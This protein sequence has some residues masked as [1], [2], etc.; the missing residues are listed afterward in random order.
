MR[1]ERAVVSLVA[2]YLLVVFSCSALE[3]DD[4]GTD[5]A[6][7]SDRDC[8]DE[9]GCTRDECVSGDSGRICRH[10]PR[11]SPCDDGDPCTSPDWC[12]EGRCVA[13][14]DICEC[15]S[16][17]DCAVHEDDDLCNGTLVCDPEARVCVVDMTTVVSCPPTASLCH[18]LVCDP[19]S[20]RCLDDNPPAGT[21]CEDDF[22]ACTYDLC[23]GD[24]ACLHSPVACNDGKPCTDD[25]CTAATGCQFEPNDELCDDDNPCTDDSCDSAEGCVHTL[26]TRSCDDGDPC[27]F[28]DGC[29]DLGL[30]TGPAIP[31][32]YLDA[33]DDGFGDPDIQLC[34]SASPDGYV[35]NDGDCCDSLDWVHPDQSSY[36]SEEYSCSGDPTDASF[37]RNCD[38][39]EERRWEE[40]G[41]CFFDG[42][43]ICRTDEGW[44]PS[45]GSGIPRC[46]RRGD[47][48]TACTVGGGGD[49]SPT[50]FEERTQECR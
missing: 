27:T 3:D 44:D 9:E 31:V 13:G 25:F 8:D 38:E 39:V 42:G 37:D 20:G 29:N 22:D 14:P 32:W 43:G 6:C 18:Q 23:D 5:D 30:C 4:A 35:S 50:G 36:S 46:G 33:D 41:E 45:A 21:P 28:P 12:S 48:L 49:C 1:L 16:H 24:G 10:T 15:D 2:A 11:T 34:D 40:R 26:H 19:A 17:G 7:S 47:W